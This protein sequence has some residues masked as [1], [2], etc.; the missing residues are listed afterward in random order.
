MDRPRSAI[1][2]ARC[3]GIHAPRS[4]LATAASGVGV[5]LMRRW[6]WTVHG[7]LSHWK[8]VAL[9]P[10]VHGKPRWARTHLELRVEV[11]RDAPLHAEASPT[12]KFGERTVSPLMWSRLSGG[13]EESPPQNQTASPSALEEGE[14][15]SARWHLEPCR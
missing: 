14:R 12:D 10:C 15:R 4:V 2:H 6:D 3:E 13:R 8:A 7:M 1:E 11:G 9:A 5:L